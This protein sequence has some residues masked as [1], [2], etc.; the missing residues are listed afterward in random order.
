MAFTEEKEP[1]SKQTTAISTT[2]SQA[3]FSQVKLLTKAEQYAWKYALSSRIMRNR[4]LLLSNG[5][6]QQ[7]IR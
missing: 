1:R 3:D 5:T 7:G 6:L 4:V 2:A